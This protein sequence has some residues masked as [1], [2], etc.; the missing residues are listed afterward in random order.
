MTAHR[1]YLS[2]VAT[3]RNDDHGGNP[4]YRMQLFVDGLIAQADR[5][6]VP[7]ELVLV[8]WNPPADRPRLADVL[9][10]PEGAGHC[11]VRIIEGPH[12]LHSPLER[13]DR[14][15]LFQMIG[16]NVG[17]RRAR[18]DLVLATNIDILF[19]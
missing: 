7:T 2:V 4:L 12:D 11:D 10:W 3:A 14:L 18:G 9:D 6:R 1:P 8:E 17:I 5:F 15:P 13:S 19:S 16:K